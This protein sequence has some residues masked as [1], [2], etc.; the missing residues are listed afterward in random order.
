M[1]VQSPQEIAQL[2][3]FGEARAYADMYQA[4]PPDSAD[5]LGLRLMETGSASARLFGS[6]NM[7]LF[8]AVVGLGVIEPANE[9]MVE[10]IIDFYRPASVSFFVQLSPVAQPAEL[11]QWL[12]NRGFVTRDSWVKM[13]RNVEPPP[14]VQTDLEIRRIGPDLAA[15]YS[16]VAL[17]AFGFPPQAQIVSPL[18]TSIVGRRGWTCYLGYDGDMPVSTAALYVDGDVG[19]CGVGATLA[20]HRGR[21][22]QGAMF[23]QRIRDAVDLGCKWI[24]TETGEETPEHPNPSYR[25]MVRMGFE[26]AYKRRNYLFKVG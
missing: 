16:E 1:T 7:V 8:N 3:E 13:Y 17:R 11:G 4:V 25:N 23:A 9:E 24:I 19:W 22:G 18:L 20:S 2:V 10:T 12:E 21:G 5:E 15:T 6:L 14:P 26:L